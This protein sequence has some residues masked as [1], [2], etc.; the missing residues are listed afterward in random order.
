MVDLALGDRDL[1]VGANPQ[2]AEDT[3]LQC[4]FEPRC[5]SLLSSLLH[6]LW[7]SLYDPLPSAPPRYHSV[8][9]F[10]GSS[11]ANSQGSFQPQDQTRPPFAHSQSSFTHG[12]SFNVASMSQQ[13]T[14]QS[15]GLR[16]STLGSGNSLNMNDSL[17]Q[18]RSPYQAGY[19]MV[20]R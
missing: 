19:L 5:L 8:L 17:A 3:V 13:G 15:P 20:S 7:R 16:T 6:P 12:Q 9:M 1:S 10:S 11:F 18:S 2:V 4:A 14:G